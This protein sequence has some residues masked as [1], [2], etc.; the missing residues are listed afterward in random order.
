MRVPAD[1]DQ[2][3]DMSSLNP[4][5]II[6]SLMADNDQ[7]I[8]LKYNNGQLQLNCTDCALDNVHIARVI[9]DW[10]NLHVIESVKAGKADGNSYDNVIKPLLEMLEIDHTYHKTEDLDTITKVASSLAKEMIDTTVLMISGDTS[11]MELLNE[12]YIG[13]VHNLKLLLFPAGSG[14]ALATSIGIDVSRSIAILAGCDHQGQLIPLF[15]V[16][17]PANSKRVYTLGDKDAMHSE[18]S[19]ISG[20]YNEANTEVTV[21]AAVVVSWALHAALVADSDSPEYRELGN[22][23]FKVAAKENLEREEGYC[24]A[25]DV[26]YMGDQKEV[27]DAEKQYSYV[28][29][30][31][32]PQL[33]PGFLIAPKSVPLS[34]KLT[35]VLMNMLPSGKVMSLLMNAYESGAHVKDSNIVHEEVERVSLKIN[36]GEERKRRICIDGAIFVLPKDAVIKILPAVYPSVKLIH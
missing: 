31:S 1:I 25:M 22:E 24:C 16:L 4:D 6:C 17:L 7:Y 32:V 5:D 15:P 36:E 34:G 12:L 33:E 13:E 10:P 18:R 2:V 8:H 3:R 35:T 20:K 9:P 21:Y 28:L 19:D 11:L 27:K 30:S 14:N 26:S 29:F 23:R